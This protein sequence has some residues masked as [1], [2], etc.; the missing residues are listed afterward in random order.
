MDSAIKVVRQLISC[1]NKLFL[2]LLM[3]QSSIEACNHLVFCL[4]CCRP[5]GG[6]GGGPAM[7]NRGAG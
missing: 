3:V 6:R 4:G 2:S 7:L 5:R 1:Q